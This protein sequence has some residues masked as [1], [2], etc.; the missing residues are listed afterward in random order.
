[1]KAW[2]VYGLGD[3]RLDDIPCPDLRPGWVIVKTRVVQPSVTE[4]QRALGIPTGGSDYIRKIIAE[5]APVQLFGHEFCAEVVEVGEGVM[6]LQPGDRVAARSE[7]PCGQCELCRTGYGDRCRKG[8]IIG[9]QIPGCLAEFAAMPSEALVKLPDSVSDSEGAWIQ[10]LSSAVA[11]VASARLEMGDSVLVLGQGAMGICAL[12]VA[13]VAGAGLVI[14][15]DV[16]AQALEMA[17]SLGADVTVNAGEDLADAEMLEATGGLGADV[18]I[19]AAGGNPGQGLAGD[20]ALRRAFQLVKDG[21]RIVQIAYLGAPIEVA[22]DSLIRAR[23]LKYLSADVPSVR[24]L[25]YAVRL[26]ASGRVQVKPLITHVLKGL[27]SVPA[28]FE[29]TANKAKYGAAGP[30]QVHL[31]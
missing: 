27:E 26:V 24:L 14:G 8:P 10:P 22:V 15:A 18:V 21:G 31:C 19:E 11:A 17:R 29:I 9:R 13:R 4:A 23:G 30:A 28:A 2:R 6:G 20:R 5:R 12:Q 16:R 25:E 7:V 3:M 1:M